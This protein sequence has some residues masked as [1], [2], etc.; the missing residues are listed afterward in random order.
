MSHKS[1]TAPKKTKNVQPK[2]DQEQVYNEQS[3]IKALIPVR[4]YSDVVKKPD[5]IP[6]AVNNNNNNSSS[7][8]TPAQQHQH[9]KQ[10]Q[11]HPNNKKKQ[12]RN[13]NNYTINTSNNTSSGKGDQVVF[14]IVQNHN[15]SRNQ[16]QQQ[17][18]VSEEPLDACNV[19]VKYLPANVT[20]EKLNELFASCGTIVSCKVM[21][22]H[23]TNTSLG[24]GFV[25]LY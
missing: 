4:L 24:Y 1:A 25:V 17:Q 15:N 20:D 2:V 12:Q 21:I 16:Q 3:P 22:D 10:S 6:A 8:S 7:S 9:A 19:F 14:G 23:K 11:S 18:S 5:A 13:N